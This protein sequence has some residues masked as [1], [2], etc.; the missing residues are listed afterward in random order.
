MLT[1][2]RIEFRFNVSLQEWTGIY[3]V[4]VS[5]K[6]LGL[7]VQLGHP[8]GKYC[9]LPQKA[10]NDDFTLIH[11][12]GIHEIGLD[13]CGCET[14][15]RHVKQLLRTAWFPATSTDPRTAATFTIL[16]QYH[17]LS[18][19]S[20][21]SGYEFY[22]SLAHLTDNTGLRPRKDRYEAFMRIVREWRHLKMLKRAG[23][24]HDPAGVGNTK[25]GEC[26][27]LCPAC[28][29]PGQ[30]L[31]DKWEEAPKETSWLYGLFLAIDANFRLKRRM[32]SKDSTD[33]GLS[34]GWAYFVEETTYKTYL[35]SHDGTLQQKSTCS[36]HNAVN[37]ADTKVSQ[38]LAAT[39][40]GT[41][42][43]TRHNMKLP[44]GVGDLQKG[45]RHVQQVAKGDWH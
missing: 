39:G 36:S 24:G 38:G 20:K 10:F 28:P 18:F 13:Y 16:E 8:A 33:P 1:I 29:Q 41:I 35:Q 25:S 21:A 31:P 15:E 40:V 30:N 7:R 44:N 42:N 9:L 34:R 14:A 37:M 26:A 12:N 2:Q 22:H 5:L 4:P 32:V 17:L 27:V 3:F 23:R 11:T 45:E 6:K 19:E 43:C